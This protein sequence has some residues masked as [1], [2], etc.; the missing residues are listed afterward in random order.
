M[1]FILYCRVAYRTRLVFDEFGRNTIFILL[2]FD[3]FF[4]TFNAYISYEYNNN[5]NIN[6]RILLLYIYIYTYILNF[7]YK[8]MRL[9]RTTFDDL[10][11]TL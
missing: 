3:R 10:K 6:T 4:R 11:K 5:F 1:R 9:D 7:V 2:A 8:C